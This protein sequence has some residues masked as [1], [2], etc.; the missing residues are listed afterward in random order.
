MKTLFVLLIIVWQI[1]SKPTD[2]RFHK[3]RTSN[4]GPLP[5]GTFPSAVI[6]KSAAVVFGGVYDDL[7]LHNNTFFNDLWMFEYFGHDSGRWIKLNPSGPKPSPRA[8]S[9]M[10]TLI[11]FKEEKFVCVIGG[12]YFQGNLFIPASGFY[13]YDVQRN[14]WLNF[15][16]LGGPS[17]RSQP[18]VLARGSELWVTG[19]VVP[20]S[21]FG[22]NTLNDLWKFDINCPSWV[23]VN[24]TGKN[25]PPRHVAVG[26]IIKDVS[27]E[28]RILMYGGE[29]I[30]FPFDFGIANDTQEYSFTENRW[31]F[32]TDEKPSPPRDY[33]S[34]VV[35]H[36]KSM[37]QI[38]G[39]DEPGPNAHNPTN[40]VWN[41]DVE[42][43]KW[44][45][46]DT[47]K[48]TRPPDTK[49]H[50]SFN[51]GDDQIIL[52]GWRTKYDENGT[53]IDQIFLM[54]VYRIGIF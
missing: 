54:D 3:V 29:T 40:Q 11:N 53:L 35:S 31:F 20:G 6:S 47:V 42:L 38:F 50:T 52:G 12:A 13:C 46:K 34:M 9:G 28:D 10:D 22:F 49:R 41:Y 48:S 32:I 25:Y 5:R 27:G 43:C 7:L 18:L 39:G 21:P 17:A 44:T 8:F 2:L 36:D 30:D 4:N 33:S 45:K 51:L 14:E 16:H 19:G 1:A 23:Q 15:T 37:A 26:G 24:V